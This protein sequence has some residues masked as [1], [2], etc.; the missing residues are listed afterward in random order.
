MRVPSLRVEVC[1]ALPERQA[2]VRLELPEGATA[3][4]AVGASG[5]AS[6]RESVRLAIFGRAVTVATALR[7]GDR[8]DILRPLAADPMESRRLRARRARR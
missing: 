6:G 7:D 8:V 5:L 2:L 4:D 3:G 1:H